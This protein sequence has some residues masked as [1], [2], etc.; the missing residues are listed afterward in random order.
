[1]LLVLQATEKRHFSSLKCLFFAVFFTFLLINPVIADAACLSA[2]QQLA[3]VD[4]WAVAAK[5][6]DGD[7]IHLND[8]RKIRIIGVNTPELGR[9]GEASRPF[10]RKAY[11][12]LVNL[13]K[14]NKKIGLTYDKD[15]KDPY[16][17]L[18]AYITLT[19]GQ[20]VE[21]ILLAKGLAHSIVVPPN[22]SRINCYRSIEKTARDANL[23]LWK[24]SENQWL[25][26][27][28]L[29]PKSKGLRFISGTVLSYSESKKSIY[30]K[31]SSK[32]SIRIAKKDRKYFSNISLKGLTGKQLR[33]R[34]WV[35]SYNGRQSI[36][37]RTSH[38]LHIISP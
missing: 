17:R 32:L 9:R 27:S 22:D 10:A 1:M 25:K 36:H 21:R 11:H 24:L 33:V 26:A 28:R 16:K 19:D 3:D 7:T 29:S 30:L 13:L 34:G 4:E 6:I 12:A 37:V 38:D 15:K 23:G 2:K 35:S 18:L 14:N 20:S 8:G 5:I 31:L